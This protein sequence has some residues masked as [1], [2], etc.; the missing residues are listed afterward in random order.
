VSVALV[1]QHAKHKCQGMLTSVASVALQDFST[2]SQ[3]APFFGGKKLLS[4]HCC[5]GFLYKFCLKISHS[6]KN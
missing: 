2:L 1:I 5:F 4:I 3:I 6:K